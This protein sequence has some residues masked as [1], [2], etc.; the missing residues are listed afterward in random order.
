[1][2]V[3]CYQFHGWSLWIF[4]GDSD[5]VTFLSWDLCSH[6]HF[7]CVVIS[8][9][10]IAIAAK[11]NTCLR[12]WAKMMLMRW[13]ISFMNVTGLICQHISSGDDKSR[14]RQA[15]KVNK[16]ISAFCSPHIYIPPNYSLLPHFSPLQHLHVH[17]FGFC[18][19]RHLYPRWRGDVWMRRALHKCWFSKVAFSPHKISWVGGH[20]FDILE[21]TSI[22]H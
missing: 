1:M 6:I 3:I 11:K 17:Y 5:F 18:G 22:A 14:W 7:L 8:S 16:G 19:L 15:M 2:I 21:N 4:T 12:Y 9:N 13:W 10:Q 20:I